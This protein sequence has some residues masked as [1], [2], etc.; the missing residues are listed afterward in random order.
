ME[1]AFISSNK[2]RIEIDK[3]KGHFTGQMLATF[4]RSPAKLIGAL[5]LGNNIALVIYG[6][7]M[8]N[9]LTPWLGKF[10]PVSPGSALFILLIQTI[11]ATL[12]ILL[13]AE[14]LPKA[15][16]RINPN[17]VLAFLAV[18]LAIFYYLLY[19]LVFLFT[20]LSEWILKYI[21]RVKFTHKERVFT[22]I[23]L[24]EYIR[25]YAENEHHTDEVQQEIQMFQNVIEFRN[26]R[27]KEC[28]VP[29]TEIIAIEENDP[30]TL[31]KEK[32]I[33]FGVSRILVFRD[34]VDH[35]IG[36]VHSFDMFKNPKDSGSI[37]NPI[38]FYPETMPASDVMAQ[39]IRDHKSIAVVVD[40]FGGTSGIVT[41]EDIFE[42]IFGEIQDEFD[43]EGMVEKMINE[44]EYIFSGRHEID[45]L[46]EKYKLNLPESDEYETLA[47]LIIHY[48]ES[49]PA[50]HE[51]ITVKPF[52]FEILQATETKIEQ[53]R[54]RIEDA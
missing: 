28:M 2:L 40:E 3:G 6:I 24:D 12:I 15:L 25:E 38:L 33:Q 42:E 9:I 5:L 20:G 50:L 35:V 46:N 19:P 43:E 17:A 13:L 21:F 18:P 29:R 7:A 23:D 32:F 4:S 36:Y 54:I 45:Y 53:V 27:L 52:H 49:I 26:A 30:V 51:T 16:F 41:L 44:K 11:F 47:G 10:F 8:A 31:L 22:P 48:H 37:I 39:F 34:T 1:I 14:F